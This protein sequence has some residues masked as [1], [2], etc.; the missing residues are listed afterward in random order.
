MIRK[1]ERTI[2]TSAPTYPP[3]KSAHCVWLNATRTTAIA[4]RLSLS[5][6]NVRWV[7]SADGLGADL[8]E[9]AGIRSICWAAPM[10]DRPCGCPGHLITYHQ[11]SMCLCDLEDNVSEVLSPVSPHPPLL[12]LQA[13]LFRGFA[14][15]SRLAI[16]KALASSPRS[17]GELAGIAGLSQ[18][19]TSN[20]LACLLD[21]GL[22]ARE[23]NGKYRVYSLVDERVPALM[24]LGAEL[25]RDH[26]AQ[27]AA[28]THM[29]EPVEVAR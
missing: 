12:T 2:K 11:L 20:H 26:A 18:P 6:R 29:G 24:T 22:V 3:L 25:L 23:R 10:G 15:P 21:C 19:A 7:R 4:R 16:L 9:T 28:C 1:P 13:K 14:D 27:V 8:G 17:V 5:G